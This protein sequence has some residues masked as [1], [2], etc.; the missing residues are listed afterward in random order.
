MLVHLYLI[1]CKAKD[2]SGL[3]NYRDSVR[4]QHGK[5]YLDI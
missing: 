3:L 4:N 2:Y 5:I 1:V